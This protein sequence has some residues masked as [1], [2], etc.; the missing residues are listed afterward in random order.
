MVQAHRQPSLDTGISRMPSLLRDVVC[1]DRLNKR[2]DGQVGFG[3]RN[4][5]YVPDRRTY[6]LRWGGHLILM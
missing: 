5:A 3:R 2:R 6:R 1:A 4:G